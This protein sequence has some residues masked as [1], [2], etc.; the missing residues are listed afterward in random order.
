MNLLQDFVSTDHIF[1]NFVKATNKHVD[2]MKQ[3]KALIKI[4]ITILLTFMV[5]KPLF[6]LL[7]KN[8][9][10][11]IPGNIFSHIPATIWHGLPL[12]LSMT[13]Y[14][15]IIPLLAIMASIWTRN[16]IVRRIINAYFIVVAALI[17]A[18]L[19]LNFALYPHW[20]FPLDSTPLFYFFSSPADAFASTSTMF[21]I[22]GVAITIAI[23]AV[24]WR[25]LTISSPKYALLTRCFHRLGVT[26][27]MLVAA[28]I[29]FLAIRG[30]FTVSTTNTGKAYYSQC[31]F[32]NHAAVN[33]LFSLMESLSHQEDFGSQYRFMPDE[34]ATKIFSKWISTSDAD[35]QPLL[36]PTAT[37]PDILI[38]VME[39]FAS[40]L[41]PSMGTHSDVAVQLDSIAQRSILFT[42]FFANSF[43]TDRGLVSVLSGYPA[44]PVHSIMKYPAKSAHLPS[45]ARSLANAKGYTSTYFYGGDVDFANQRSW[46]VSQGYQRIISDV[47]FPLKDK[48]SKWGVPDHIVAQRL[49]SDIR[50]QS[51][52]K[53]DRRPHFRVFQTS[54]SHEPY[55]V[56]YHRLSDK[57]LNSFAYSDSVFGNLINQYSK[58]PCWDN[59]LIIFVPDHVGAYKEHLD[60][61]KQSRYEIPLI[62][63]GGA[64]LRP[65]KIGAIGSQI[66]IAATLLAQLGINHSDF[67]FSKNIMS[68]ATP[69]M[70]F[71][72]VPDAFGFTTDSASIIFDNKLG[73]V[74]YSTGKT[75]DKNEAYGKAYLQKL[76]DDLDKK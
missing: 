72:T 28:A 34:E 17:S 10:A 56:P 29:M 32:L 14:L 40:D 41:M 67:T 15:C 22:T 50:Q 25:L 43:R 59:A 54:S 39:G 47:D 62:I 44:Q 76:Y 23:A 57:R 30:G 13:G 27:A 37:T 69:K 24:I 9:D 26:A 7:L 3:I 65:M 21:A 20:S 53:N 12:D 6:L 11:A 35:T 55:D 58:L 42:N 75:A 52:N 33:P 63:T 51:A 16:D 38:V 66:D 31:A 70:A 4:Y 60:N 74:V 68:S 73:K 8:D 71:Y 19:T 46:L 61:F 48:L 1:C 45:L 49:L 36:K 5:Q 18:S 2:N 64:I